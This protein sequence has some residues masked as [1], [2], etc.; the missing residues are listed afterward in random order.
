M[1]ERKCDSFR[2]AAPLLVSVAV[3]EILYLMSRTAIRNWPGFGGLSIIDQELA[4]SVPRA[5]CLVGL[6]FAFHHFNAFPNFLQKPRFKTSVIVSMTLLLALAVFER[7]HIINGS[8]ER[9]TYTATTVLVAFREELI[10]RYVLQT[11]IAQRVRHWL[12][13]LGVVI[14]TSIAFTLMHLGAQPVSMFPT[15]FVA[16]VLLGFIYAESQSVSLAIACHFV[17][18]LFYF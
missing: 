9:F 4:R 10:Y 2:F 5:V 12:H 6:L 14:L 16:S 17:V 13:P 3:L 8:W 11:W 15:I 18:D 7:K 1:E